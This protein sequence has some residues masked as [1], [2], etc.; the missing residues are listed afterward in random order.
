MIARSTALTA[1]SIIRHKLTNV[2]TAEEHEVFL[3]LA[4]R[5]ARHNI[6]VLV[7]LDLAGRLLGILSERDLVRA[8]ARLS[9][10]ALALS[11]RDLMTKKVTTCSPDDTEIQLML[12]MVDKHIRHMPVVEDGRV[13]G[14]VSLGDVVQHRLQKLGHRRSED[15]P[16]PTL[17]SIGGS[18]SRHLG[19]RPR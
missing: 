6:G 5:L 1:R 11:A 10:G 3:M 9:A 18:F 16:A 12:V 13:V 19:V 17:E 8:I 4:E 15:R 2:I 7:V 14:L